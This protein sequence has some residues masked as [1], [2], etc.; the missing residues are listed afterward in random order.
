MKE[1]ERLKKLFGLICV[2]VILGILAAC[3]SSENAGSE[4]SSEGSKDEKEPVEI[5]LGVGYATEENLWL[6][7]VASDLAP[8]YGKK[9]TLDLQQFR[10]NADRLNAYRAGQIHGGT[11]GQGTAIMSVAQGVDLKIVASIAKETPGVGFNSTFMGLKDSGINSAADLKGKT[12]GIPDFKSPTDMWARSAVRA[13]GLDPD[14]DVKYA[15]LPTPAVKEAVESGKID[16]GL[17]PQ[18]FYDMAKDSSNLKAVFT[19]K[20]GVPID[21]DFFNLF[22]DPKFIKENPEAVQALIDDFKVMTKYYVENPKE[23]RQ[24]LLDAEFVL[25]EPEIYLNME[26]Y[27]RS[28]DSSFNKE[29]WELVQDILITEKW[30]DKKIDIDNLIDDSFVSKK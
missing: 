30:I 5:K 18:P 28:V 12:I 11:I 8:N 7:K 26:D 1:G 4:K 27:N 24:K 2:F 9:Y 20:D 15:V 23:A 13:A 21:E 25:A 10:A 14:K 29:S 22:L 6:I 17:F 16:V 19:S 3:N